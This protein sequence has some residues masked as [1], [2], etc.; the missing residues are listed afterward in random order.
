M[1]AE[2]GRGPHVSTVS[3]GQLMDPT[4]FI[5]FA[6]RCAPGAPTSELSAIVRRAS[7]F[8]PLVIS[9]VE[10]RKPITI[11]ATSKPEA[12][13][14]A[15]EMIIAGQRVR[16]GLAGVDARDLDRL[17][18]SLANAFEPCPNIQ[19]AAR[20]MS[21]DPGRLKP[22]VTGAQ[23]EL[24]R[25]SK[26]VEASDQISPSPGAIPGNILRVVTPI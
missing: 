13:G 12:I 21:E 20:L 26:V 2:R 3:L 19:I 8:E 9:T 23:R 4:A 1:A 10:G 15:T 22:I 17:K 7:G 6:E 14:L 11:Q 5:S 18:V 16:I 25:A 24:R